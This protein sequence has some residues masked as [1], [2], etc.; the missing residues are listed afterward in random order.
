MST[1][2]NTS[3]TAASALPAAGGSSSSTLSAWAGPYVTNMLGQA[4]AL[5]QQDCYHVE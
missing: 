1:L 3:G 4:Q 2:A 5:S